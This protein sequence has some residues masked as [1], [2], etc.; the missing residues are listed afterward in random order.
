MTT[1]DEKIPGVLTKI[2]AKFGRTSTFVHPALHQYDRAT[3]TTTVAAPITATAKITPPSPWRRAPLPGVMV[4]IGDQ[5][6]VVQKS[7]LGFTPVAGRTM[8]V[9]TG[10][11]WTVVGV[12]EICTGDLVVAYVL[13]LRS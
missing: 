2:L 8:I 13:Q 9:E 4:E 7:S 12:A 5:Q 11:R 10:T 3:G 6:T 1:L